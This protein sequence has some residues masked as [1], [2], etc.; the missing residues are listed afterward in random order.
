MKSASWLVEEERRKISWR[1]TSLKKWLFLR[2]QQKIGMFDSR[3]KLTPEVPTVLR[4]VPGL[5]RRTRTARSVARFTT[6]PRPQHS[7][8]ICTL[9][10]T[11]ARAGISALTC[12]PGQHCRNMFFILLF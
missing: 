9:C 7:S 4:V 12:Q 5:E 10:A 6:R 1:M 11:V 3:D 8:C 2:S